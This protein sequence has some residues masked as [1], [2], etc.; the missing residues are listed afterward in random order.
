MTYPARPVDVIRDLATLLHR[1]GLTRLYWSACT[2]F[3]VVSVTS[4]LTVWT[5]GRI[6]CWQQE[7][8]E[9]RWPISDLAGAAAHL[10]PMAIGQIWHES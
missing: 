4:E 2:L 5:D 3:A 8:T 10:A 9:T 7:G 6:L 1:R